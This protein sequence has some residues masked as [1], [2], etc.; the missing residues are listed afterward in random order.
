[1]ASFWIAAGM[2]SFRY[3]YQVN[4]NTVREVVGGKF[5]LCEDSFGLSVGTT[6][7]EA[8]P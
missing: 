3:D 7:L 5:W 2:L 8:L 4:H 1:M 6:A